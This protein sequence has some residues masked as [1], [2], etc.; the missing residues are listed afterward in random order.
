[1]GLSLFTIRFVHNFLGD[2][3]R[4]KRLD[5]ADMYLPSP[6]GFVRTQPFP[7]QY[8]LTENGNNN[9]DD[10]DDDLVNDS[11]NFIPESDTDRKTILVLL[12]VAIAVVCLG[13]VIIIVAVICIF[14]R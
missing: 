8:P 5:L 9:D 11:L 14:K 13:I 3:G 12:S 7:Y 1:M 10:D 6:K 4:N 2:G